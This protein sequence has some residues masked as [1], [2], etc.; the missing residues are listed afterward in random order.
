MSFW[1]GS[2]MT[3][4]IHD[5]LSFTF[6]QRAVLAGALIALCAA[7]LGVSLVL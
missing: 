4:A 1:R 3:T 6:L 5:L 7:L 2:I